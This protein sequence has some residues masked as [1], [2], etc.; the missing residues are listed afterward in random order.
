MRRAILVAVGLCCLSQAAAAGTY[1]GN[2]LHQAC[3]GKSDTP[4]CDGY[5][6][7]IVDV[8]LKGRVFCPPPDVTPRQFIDIG[9]DYLR[10]HPERRHYAAAS[11]VISALKEKFP[12]TPPETRP[13]QRSRLR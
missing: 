1:D 9:K 5:M 3:E 6:L 7:G 4:L 8:L 11:L 12:C 2:L 13:R 10:D